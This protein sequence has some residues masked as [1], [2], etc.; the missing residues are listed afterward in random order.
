MS[1]GAADYHNVDILA[2]LKLQTIS[3]DKLVSY[4]T[5]ELSGTTASEIWYLVSDENLN[6]TQLILY[7]PSEYGL[8]Y[9]RNG[10]DPAAGNCPYDG[11]CAFYD[12]DPIYVKSGYTINWTATEITAV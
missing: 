9:S 12:S 11:A 3:L 5:A 4:S 2:E 8:S 7:N 10:A 1:S 6:R